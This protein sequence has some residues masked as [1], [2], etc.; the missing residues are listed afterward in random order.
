MIVP[1]SADQRLAAAEGDV[2][3]RCRA[4][5]PQIAGWTIVAALYLAAQ[6]PTLTNSEIERLARQF[7]FEKLPIPSVTGIRDRTARPVHPSLRHIASNVSF[8]GAAVALADIDGDGLP[9][10][11][12][13]VDP[14]VDQIAVAPVPGTGDR[15][16]PFVLNAGTL[17]FDASSTAPMGTLIGDFDEDGQSDVLAYYWGRSPVLFLRRSGDL[18]AHPLDA[19]TAQ[20]FRPHELVDPPQIWNTCAVTQADLDG[21]GHLDL[22]VGNY[23][24]D[25]ARILDEGAAGREQMNRSFSRAYN[26]GRNRLFLAVPAPRDAQRLGADAQLSFREAVGVL[27]DDVACGWTFAVGAVDL[28]GDLLPE[29]YF[30][31]DFGPDRLLHNRSGPGRLEFALLEGERGFTTPRSKVL[32]GDSFNGMGIDFGDVNGDGLPD[33]FVSNITANYGL[34]ESNFLFI[35][36]PQDLP[37]MQQG[38][39]PYRDDSEG[40]GVSRSGWAWDARLADFDND[41]VLEAMQA[42]G[43]VKGTVDRWPELQ[44]LGVSND[45]VISDPRAWPHLLPGDDVSGSDHNPFFV[46]TSDGR[47]HDLAAAIGIAEP[48]CTRGIALA[49]TDGD[50]RLDFAVANQWEPSYMFHNSAPEPGA[51]L[52]LHLRL[53]VNATGV[54]AATDVQAGHPRREVASRPAIG[55]V[56]T[57]QLADG[58]LLTSQVDGGTGHSGKRSPDLLFGLGRNATGAAL[59]VNVRWRGT[60]GQVRAE[61]LQVAPG[62]HTVL[63]RDAP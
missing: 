40:L 34:H 33:I 39:A 62:W 5:C 20:S 49:D 57:V 29:I 13:S 58:R 38:I 56:A 10:D 11:L 18:R 63:L 31:Q 59:A 7:R 21:D 35:S 9:N 36:R 60:D 14:R 4:L 24:P 32:G 61:S 3:N 47:F 48:M 54:L 8:V 19:P 2:V 26:G 22:I 50:G 28:D 45:R 1:P 12:V 15:Y 25:D 41:G 43:F 30:V 51:F 53:P 55:A 16:E 27:A 37:R 17:H 52:G 44:E 6:P 42:A 23:Y 46:R